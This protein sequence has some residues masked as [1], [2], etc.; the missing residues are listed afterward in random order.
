MGYFMNKI[1][2][3][4]ITATYARN[5]VILQYP[6]SRTTEKDLF[7]EKKKVGSRIKECAAG[8]S[9]VF[10]YEECKRGTGCDTAQRDHFAAKNDN[11]VNEGR[12]AYCRFHLGE[13]I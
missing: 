3:I 8:L 1:R 13:R 4:D 10:T 6:V 2:N 9:L 7:R 5:N 11:A 12:S